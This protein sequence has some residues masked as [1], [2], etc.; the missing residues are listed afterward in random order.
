[1]RFS[2]IFLATRQAA[3]HITLLGGAACA[4]ASASLTQEVC[5]GAAFQTVLQASPASFEAHAVWLNRRLARW[6]GADTV[7]V[8]TLYH[9]PAGTINATPGAKVTGAHWAPSVAL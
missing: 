6:P 2:L 1:M 4:H 8:F 7:G 9:S 3:V 5:N